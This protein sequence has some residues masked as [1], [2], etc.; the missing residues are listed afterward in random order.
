MEVGS[1][2]MKARGG[3]WSELAGGC[4]AQPLG[5][6]SSGMIVVMVMVRPGDPLTMST[7]FEE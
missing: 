6:S 4:R 2:I 5:G 3:R 7:G 1:V